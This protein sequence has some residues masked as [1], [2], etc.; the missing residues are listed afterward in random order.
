MCMLC[1]R[2]SVCVRACVWVYVCVCAY[3]HESTLS[4]YTCHACFHKTAVELMYKES[5]KNYTEML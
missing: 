1:V 4:G 3:V 5:M 2:V